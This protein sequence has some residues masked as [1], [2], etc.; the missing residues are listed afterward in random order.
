MI[1]GDDNTKRSHGTPS[2]FTKTDVPSLKSGLPAVLQTRARRTRV[3]KVLGNTRALFCDG[4]STPAYQ[5]KFL[6]WRFCHI[7]VAQ[8]TPSACEE[9]HNHWCAHHTFP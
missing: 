2:T 8:L 5:I 3:R 1:I 6:L 7:G 9:A 4:D